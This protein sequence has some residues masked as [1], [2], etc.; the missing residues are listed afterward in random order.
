MSFLGSA[1]GS[2]VNVAGGLLGG[3]LS[4]KANSA[5]A[6]QANAYNVENYQHR[7]QW[8]MEDLKKAGLNPILA[9]TSGGLTGNVNGAAAL[10]SPDMAGSLSHGG[11][12]LNNSSAVA[13]QKKQANATIDNLKADTQVKTASAAAQLMNNDFFK[14]TYNMRIRQLEL[15]IANAEKQGKN[16]D[17]DTKL[18]M[19]QQVVADT[20]QILNIAKAGESTANS[21]RSY[22]QARGENAKTDFLGRTGHYP[23]TADSMFGTGNNIVDSF[24]K[25]FGSKSYDYDLGYHGGD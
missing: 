1:L 10:S 4:N 14:D 17:E 20:L 16:I 13:I 2:V 6:A 7:Y 21:A 25:K 19:R 23:N 11:D 5:S 9:V 18:K 22:A 3:A 12:T 24:L 8:T 15:A